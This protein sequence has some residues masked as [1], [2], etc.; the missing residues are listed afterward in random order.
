MIRQ[1]LVDPELYGALR[2]V[3]GP[4]ISADDLGVLVTHHTARI[5]G[6]RITTD[7]SLAKDVLHLICR[8][9][10]NERFP[11]LRQNRRPRPYELKQAIRATTAMH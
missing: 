11:W 8:M 1:I 4:P 2:Y 7:P 3:A 9:A 5:S 6:K 10:D